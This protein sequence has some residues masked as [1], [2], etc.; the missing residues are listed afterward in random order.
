MRLNVVHLV[1]PTP[2]WRSELLEMLLHHANV[3]GHILVVV[4]PVVV[5]NERAGL[6]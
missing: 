3:V 2:H 6:L 4:S 5:M 1:W